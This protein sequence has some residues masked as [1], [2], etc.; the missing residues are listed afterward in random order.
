MSKCISRHGQYLSRRYIKV[1]EEHELINENLTSALMYMLEEG[2]ELKREC[3]FPP[4]YHGNFI[5]E[6]I[7]K[8]AAVQL[9]S[10]GSF[11]SSQLGKSIVSGQ[12]CAL[13]QGF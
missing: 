4:V 13:L 8:K 5:S 9:C 6:K 3:K 12:P 11:L 7:T 10:K 1:Y 2:L